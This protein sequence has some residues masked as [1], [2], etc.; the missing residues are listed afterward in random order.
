[1]IKEAGRIA[2]R[3]GAEEASAVHVDQAAN[4][5]YRR[6]VSRRREATGALGGLFAG[7]GAS[8]LVTFLLEEQTHIAGIGVSAV[9]L[10]V[11]AGMFVWSFSNG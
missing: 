1:L 8:T 3:Y 6:S 4:H 10:A 9:A 2:D 11:G 5:L 7:L